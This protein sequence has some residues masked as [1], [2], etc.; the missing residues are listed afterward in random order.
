MLA[1][2]GGSAELPLH[3]S[4]A[5][6]HN[7]CNRGRVKIAIPK[8]RR[9]WKDLTRAHIQKSRLAPPRFPSLWPNVSERSLFVREKT[10]KILEERELD[11]ARRHAHRLSQR[12]ERRLASKNA[13]QI[14][15]AEDYLQFISLI[16][17]QLARQE[18]LLLKQAS[19]GRAAGRILQAREKIRAETVEALRTVMQ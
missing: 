16:L 8:A 5:R 7:T 18:N 2:T 15:A 14:P 13:L 12:R 1:A 4:L 11:R 6:Y 17:V 10:R 3:L 9:P 19:E